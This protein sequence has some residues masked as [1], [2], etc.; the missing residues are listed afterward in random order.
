M[1]Q[2]IVAAILRSLDYCNSV[3]VD[4]PR[5]DDEIAYVMRENLV[6]QFSLPHSAV[7]Q[8]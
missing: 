1:K 3:L 8:R 5:Y 4:L 6:A 7:I 2:L